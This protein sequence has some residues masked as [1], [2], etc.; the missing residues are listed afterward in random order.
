MK[1]ANK[2]KK[3]IY[4]QD[5][6]GG[7]GYYRTLLSP[8]KVVTR[9]AFYDMAGRN[10]TAPIDNYLGVDKLPFNMTYSMM[11]R[12]AAVAARAKSFA[13]ASKSLK[14]AGYRRVSTSMV[15]KV[16]EVVGQAI[17]EYYKKRANIVGDYLAGGNKIGL[18][19][20]DIHSFDSLESKTVLILM[21]DGHTIYLRKY[22]TGNFDIN[23]GNK[24]GA[25]CRVGIAFMLSNSSLEY[26]ENGGETIRIGS[27]DIIALIS[28][29]NEFKNYF[30]D[31][32]LR[33]GAE[34]CDLIVVVSD[35][36]DWIHNMIDELF[37]S[38]VHIRDIWHLKE[39]IG[40]FCKAVFS[41]DSEKATI[42]AEKLCT[43]IDEGNIN[44]Y[45]ADLTPYKDCVVN[46]NGSN[47]VNPYGYVSSRKDGM[48][49]DLYKKLGLPIGSGAMESTNK[50]YHRRMRTT[51]ALW[52]K[53]KAN[54]MAMIISAYEAGG[55]ELILNILL[56][57]KRELFAIS[58]SIG[59]DEKH[60]KYS[61]NN[62]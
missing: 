44:Q 16:C 42:F 25:D 2:G 51:G 52:T 32:A 48:E 45:L 34:Q 50:L 9:K 33:N 49:Y 53:P 61:K 24:C 21:V 46:V 27:K 26:D 20:V 30:G 19:D 40:K 4:V 55:E 14:E 43:L 62:T 12:T 56:S 38:Y 17:W 47:L 31:L 57:M 35:G 8:L 37:S 22:S 54:R 58:N 18:K 15:D 1:L 3:Y 41:D 11:A 7:I 36:A 60:R 28:P 23:D 5:V 59:K 6:N 39:C 10:S 13:E 29:K